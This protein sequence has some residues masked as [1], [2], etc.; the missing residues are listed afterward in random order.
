MLPLETIF[1]IDTTTRLRPVRL[2]DASLLF[3]LVH[4]NRA[5]L[6]EWTPWVD[7][8]QSESDQVSFIT[9]AVERGQ[10]GLGAVWLVE[11]GD[12]VCGVA[13][14]NW[15][16]P[17]NRVCEVGYWLAADHQGRGIMTACVGRLVRHAFEDLGLNR[18]TLP[19]A[20]ENRRSR[21]IAERLGFR[22][23][24]TLREAE[25][26]YDHFVDHVLYTQIR[27]EWILRSAAT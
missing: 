26:L 8:C 24:G 23:E 27:S 16:E 20:V 18:V 1:D 22:I 7:G 17:L 13:G 4:A 21:A 3:R 12:T 14:F 6:R 2:A 19:V 10:A 15:V 9:A 11:R 5:H 25:W